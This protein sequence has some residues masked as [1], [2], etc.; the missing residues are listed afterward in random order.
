MATEIQASTPSQPKFSRYRSVRRATLNQTSAA[1][2]IPP[3]QSQYAENPVPQ[4]PSRYK[5]TPSTKGSNV[6]CRG[7]PSSPG[8]VQ[9]NTATGDSFRREARLEASRTKEDT[10]AG[11]VRPRDL[12]PLDDWDRP[13][14]E[15]SAVRSAEP[16]VVQ[17]ED[18]KDRARREAYEILTGAVN[19]PER[20]SEEQRTNT[21]GLKT[22]GR[23]KTI[24]SSS[25]QGR[26]GLQERSGPPQD[27]SLDPKRNYSPKKQ[28]TAQVVSPP[29]PSSQRE[30]GTRQQA[31]SPSRREK[32]AAN[33]LPNPPN[34]QAKPK[35]NVSPTVGIHPGGGGIVPG[36]DAPKSAVNAGARKVLVKMNQQS[37]FLPVTPST[38][39]VDIIRSAANVLSENIDPST[40][41]LLE[42]FKELGLE[43]P[44]RKYE[45]I[46]DVLNAW[47]NDA[48]N[49][50]M[51]VP[52]PTNG[53]DDDLDIKNTPSRQP[54]DISVRMYHS[55]RPGHWDKRL[56][57]LR[58]DG[59]VYVEK[60]RGGG[61]KR[62][63][64]HL[65]D[66]D[67]YIP[68]PRQLSKR[69]K[70]PKKLCFAV[71]S[72]QKSS[73]FLSGQNFVHFF[74]TRDKS[75]AAAWY[76]A[77]QEWR[78]WYLVNVLGEGQKTPKPAEISTLPNPNQSLNY[79]LQDHSARQPRP[80]VDSVP[81]Q[82]GSFKPLMAADDFQQF[83]A[84]AP[85]S[86][87]TSPT[88]E[89]TGTKAIYDR[90]KSVRN[91]GAPPVSFPKK[92]TKDPVTGTPTTH[93]RGPDLIRSTSREQDQE[94]F[95]SAGLLGR[96]Y[97]QRQR[98]QSEQEQ[99]AAFEPPF[100]IQSPLTEQALRPAN[101]RA[102]SI[103]SINLESGGLRRTSS[104]RKPQKP[105]VDLTPR[106]QEPIQ[107]QKKGR[108]VVLSRLPAGGLVDVA[109]SPDVAIPIPSSNAW[110]RPGTSGGQGAS[111]TA[112]PRSASA[113]AQGTGMQRNGTVHGSSRH[114]ILN[115]GEEAFTG[116]LLA[117]V[118]SGRS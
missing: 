46:R 74:S 11:I 36:I 66:F 82:I 40:S 51:I 78:S 30:Q 43:R 108:G 47:D 59:Q 61:E 34:P 2:S 23:A 31:N 97:S 91:R 117:H 110:Q 77:V 109:N 102:M 62:N 53:S 90:N 103:R 76:K 83:D 24:A 15:L 88:E 20:S 16:L 79:N 69:I 10:Q 1:P 101:G 37:I 28:S 75:L 26:D 118:G 84:P 21:V 38:A 58:S 7:S 19:R 50:L 32:K 63:I 112:W 85:L 96:T 95:A 9:Q 13:L 93:D 113:S 18:S 114:A 89:I 55:Q 116:G 100:A 99:A 64:C 111:T 41:V 56:I 104:Q 42:T 29:V 33:E 45:R 98:A 86:Q 106:Y 80:S 27:M 65:S 94:T 49:N 68:T 87:L 17:E 3:P 72:Q 8:Q 57:T 6:N 73:M 115:T 92:L 44:L 5:D 52:S 48:Q 14:A 25:S 12:Q 105:L 67:I 60:E 107:H 81:Y 54:D 70:P 39:A 4:I 35:K 71:K 22:R